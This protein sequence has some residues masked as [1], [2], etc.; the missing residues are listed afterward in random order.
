VEREL[1]FRDGERPAEWTV[2]KTQIEGAAMVEIG[3]IPLS[4]RR[5]GE[6]VFAYGTGRV[7]DQNLMAVVNDGKL[8]IRPAPPSAP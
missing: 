1:Y 8:T 3:E 6:I 4:H 2:E 7:G 5:L